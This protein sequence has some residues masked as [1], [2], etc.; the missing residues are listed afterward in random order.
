MP[1]VGLSRSEGHT[2]GSACHVEDNCS[3]FLLTLLVLREAWAAKI[4][5]TGRDVI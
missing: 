4:G 2:L 3:Y 5:I 1:V